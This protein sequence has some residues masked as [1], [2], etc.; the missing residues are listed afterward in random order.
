MGFWGSSL[1]ANDS[2]CDVRD[3]YLNLLKKQLS[4]DEAYD[5]LIKNS[6]EMLGT[7]EEPLFWYALAETQ[8]KLGRLN[9]DV[10]DKALEWIGK[11]GGLVFWKDSANNGKGWKKTLEKLKLK[12]ESPQP[13]RKVVKPKEEC[14]T[15]P[16]EIGD[17]YAYQLHNR[18]VKDTPAFGKYVAIQKVGNG[19]YFDGEIISRVQFFDKLY[20]EIPDI[21]DVLKQ[22]IL[23]LDMSTPSTMNNDGLDRCVV[24]SLT[25]N[26]GLIIDKKK[27][28][29]EKYLTYLGNT[30]KNQQFTLIG[31]MTWVWWTVLDDFI[32]AEHNKWHDFDY[33]IID[34]KL[35]GGEVIV[36][37]KNKE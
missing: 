17:I 2:T 23:P 1:Y 10:K 30:T 11:N 20:D 7:D 16:W 36:T 37:R 8:W 12:L 15:N 6:G 21:E 13:A 22:R 27:E 29:P 14:V 25:L 4:D 28:Y 33:E 24:E 35:F 32:Y 5:E 18:Y 19:D 34:Y 3:T 31:N 9:P 26:F